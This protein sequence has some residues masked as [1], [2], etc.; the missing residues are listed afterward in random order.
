MNIMRMKVKYV[1]FW[2]S[3]KTVHYDTSPMTIGLKGY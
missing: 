3:V 2:K 1:V